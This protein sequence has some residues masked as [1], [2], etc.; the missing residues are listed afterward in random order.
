MGL[1]VTCDARLGVFSFYFTVAFTMA[2]RLGDDVLKHF[3]HVYL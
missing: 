3:R 2:W 1:S